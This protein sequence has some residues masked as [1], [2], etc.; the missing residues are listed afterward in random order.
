[1][2]AELVA[3]DTP[4]PMTAILRL[5]NPAAL[6]HEGAGPGGTCRSCAARFS[7]ASDV[8]QNPSANKSDR[9]RPF[10]FTSWERGQFVRL[11]RNEQYWK[12]GLP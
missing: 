4:D 6:H 8:L 12:P 3:V 1:M 9:H 2:L 11:D 10:K 5:A 7:R